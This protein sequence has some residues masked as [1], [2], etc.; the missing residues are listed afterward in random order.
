MIINVFSIGDSN[1][2]STW[3]NIPYYFCY[4]LEK[5]LIKVNR[6]NIEPNRRIEAY[7]DFIILRIIKT[8]LLVF[9][10]NTTFNYS[11]SYINYFLTNKKIKKACRV[12]S[13]AKY[14]VFLTYSF[15][16][17]SHSS[18]PVINLC[19]FTYHYHI[20]YMNKR[21]PDIF[22]RYATMQELKNLKNAFYVISLFPLMSEY[23]KRNYNILNVIYLGY[24]LNIPESHLCKV[25]PEGKQ[26]SY[27]I[28]FIGRRR[29]LEGLIILMN[30][31]GKLP[32]ELNKKVILHVVGL[33][34]KDLDKNIDNC[35]VKYYGFL[36]KNNSRERNLFFSILH[37]A[38]LFINPTSKWAAYTSSLEAMHYFTPIVIFPYDEFTRTFGTD[39]NFGIYLDSSDSSYMARL[40]QNLLENNNIWE[41]MAIAAHEV[42]EKYRWDNYIQKFIKILN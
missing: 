11:R 16:S 32:D 2:L 5:N 24:I 12:Y 42:T 27:D 9:G 36:D 21:Q 8:I 20:N 4:Y 30:A 23:I 31:I 40:I 37:N 3:S 26:N 35:N 34:N 41:K 19:D 22:E 6:I 15:S 18:I 10:K 14:N 7:Y 1:L 38:K 33:T 25:F 29:Y 17:Y 28:L 13:F 39:I